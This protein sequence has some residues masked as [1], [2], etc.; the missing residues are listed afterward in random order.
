MFD[1]IFSPSTFTLL[2]IVSVI[3]TSIYFSIQKRNILTNYKQPN[4]KEFKNIDGS[5][6]SK[7]GI[8]RQKFEWCTF[9]ILVNENSVFLFPKSFHIIPS[10]IINLVYSTNSSKYTRQTKN[11]RQVR[12]L[13]INKDNVEIVFMRERLMFE[14]SKLYLKNLSQEQIILLESVLNKRITS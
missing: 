6:V 8:L 11:P 13:T 3:I 2:A 5:I 4:S 1:I 9:D 12:Q 7:S 14:T 10:R